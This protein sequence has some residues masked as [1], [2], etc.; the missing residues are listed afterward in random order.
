[1]LFTF[2]LGASLV[3]PLFF[4]ILLAQIPNYCVVYGCNSRGGEGISLHH[5]PKEQSIKQKW[6]NFVKS[7][8]SGWSGPSKHSVICSKH[9]CDS[10]Y[11]DAFRHS[12]DGNTRRTLKLDAVP[13]VFSHENSAATRPDR[14]AFVKR[15]RRRVRLY[16]ILTSSSFVPG[17][18]FLNNRH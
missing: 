4:I 10:Q 17:C 3:F 11:Q 7:H 2:R 6:I 1:V 9:F 15:E 14:A 12:I 16:C 13:S 5:F 8:R 18:F